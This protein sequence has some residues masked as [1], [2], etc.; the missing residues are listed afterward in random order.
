MTGSGKT[1]II[2]TGSSSLKFRL[3]E[4]ERILIDG[5]IEGIKDGYSN[6]TKN[7]I[8]RIKKYNIKTINKIVYRIVHGGKM[9]S[10]SIL[11]PKLMRKIKSLAPLAPLHMLPVIKVIEA[12]KIID[13]KEIICFDTSFHLTIPELAKR[14]AI[15]VEIADKNGIE[16]Y[17]FHGLAHEWMF[18]EIERRTGEKYSK[19]ISCQLGNGVSICAIKD[20]KSIDTS[21]GFTPLEGLMMG[22][23]S[24]DIDPAIIG[25]LSI[26]GKSVSEVMS[27]LENE[28]GFKGITGISDVREIIKMKRNGN[29]RAKIALEMFAY[30]V[31]KYI[32]AYAAALGGVDLIVLGGGV[33][34][35]GEIREKILSDIEYLGVELDANKISS[36][37]PVKISKGDVD[38]WVIESD[39]QEIMFEMTRKI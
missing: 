4:N 16:K 22:T 28:S 3:Y 9:K 1:L 20:G 29:K 30:R 26:K 17:G 18:R 34:R 19:V 24:G 37:S 15:P 36:P 8:E 33:S 14:Y 25:Y 7:V 13:A 2:N 31:K 12:L 35:A 11:T 6:A 32:G 38:V 5:E 21:M 39:E 10:P 27:M 23:R